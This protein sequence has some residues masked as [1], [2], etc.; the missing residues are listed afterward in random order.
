MHVSAKTLKLYKAHIQKQ[1]DLII[2]LIEKIQE[3]EEEV[4]QLKTADLTTDE[5]SVECTPPDHMAKLE[6]T[7]FGTALESRVRN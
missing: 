7:I 5:E 2:K 1:D 4:V 6:R 3:L